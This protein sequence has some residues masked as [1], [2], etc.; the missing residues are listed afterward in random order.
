MCVSGNTRRALL[1][2]ALVL[3]VLPGCRVFTGPS[4]FYRT[5]PA[6]PD[7]QPN[8]DEIASHLLDN[9]SATIAWYRWSS[10]IFKADAD[11][12][13]YT[14]ALTRFHFGGYNYLDDVP[15]PANAVPDPAGDGHLTVV[16]TDTKCVYD[17]FEADLSNRSAPKASWANR[18][19]QDGDGI[20]DR[21]ASGRGS[22]FSNTLGLMSPLDFWL[23]EIPHALM[24]SYHTN[25]KG[26]PVWPAT[27][28]DGSSDASYGIPEGARLFLPRSFDLSPYPQWVQV[29][30]RALQEYGA[31]DG[32]NGGSSSVLSFY[33]LNPLGHPGFSQ[34]LYPWGSEHWPSLPDAMIRSLRAERWGSQTTDQHVPVAS[35]CGNYR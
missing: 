15:I 12:P 20:Y 1:C 29:I 22:G 11:T 7:T 24:Y 3:A 35:R 13:R 23:G 31:Y 4:P 21:G 5:L 18:I 8:S 26:G 10:T 34:T 28:S 14:V 27:E 32:D 2:V 19:E 6:T 9:G 17:L 16:D 30:G 25:K 33:A